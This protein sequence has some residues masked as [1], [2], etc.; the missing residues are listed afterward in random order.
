M[1]DARCHEQTTIHQNAII[2]QT[3]QP[4]PSE[5]VQ[6]AAHSTPAVA[7]HVIGPLSQ[8]LHNLMQLPISSAPLRP[9]GPSSSSP[10]SMSGMLEP[11]S[12]SLNGQLAAPPD[13]IAISGLAESLIHWL[14]EGSVS[15]RMDDCQE[16]GPSGGHEGLAAHAEFQSLC[17]IVID[18]FL[19]T[20]I[21]HT[22]TDDIHM[23]ASRIRRL[24]KHK[25]DPVWFPWPDKVV[26]APLV[27]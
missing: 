9:S 6:L 7:D 19:S 4:T 27:N 10:G 2:F 16:P 15:S 18:F 24:K 25:G 8:I 14:D 22:F 17:T 12:I 11:G 26:R 13:Q 20:S 23:G 5:N 1:K 21:N 3:S